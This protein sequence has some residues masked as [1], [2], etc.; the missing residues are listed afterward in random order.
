[1]SAPIAN[2]RALL[3]AT[4]RAALRATDAGALV[5]ARLLQ[6]GFKAPSLVAAFGKAS[7]PM[8]DAALS[9]YP[10][11][12]FLALAPDGLEVSPA[13]QAAL[14]QGQ[15][16]LHLARHPVP[17]ER[18]V[19]GATRLLELVNGLQAGADL[20][21]L[22][23][24]GGSAL[25]CAPWGVTLGQKQALTR[26]LLASGASIHD[27]NT[28]RKHLSHVKGGR[29]AQAALGRGASVTALLLSD[30]IGDDPSVIASGPTVPDASTFSDALAVLGR[31]G[32]GHPAA[33]AHL[34]RGRAGELP[35]T[36]NPG[37][38]FARVHTEVIGSN[39]LLLN[40]AAAHLDSQG[41]R[42]I[43]LG[44]A[45]GGEARDLAATH[46]AIIRSVY[47]SGTPALAPVALISGGEA[48]VTLGP[49]FVFDA[50]PGIGGRNQEF[51]LAFLME[52]G[53]LESEGLNLNL[54]GLSAGSDGIDGTS[55]AA[56]A[57]LMPDS[58]VR[59]RARGLDP[60]AALHRHDSGTF[61]AALGDALITGP[62]GQ[63]LNDLRVLL[64]L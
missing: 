7:L 58:L 19:R 36:P 16:E 50:A 3:D 37:P 12:R 21:V 31:F 30:V 39:R 22:G 57:F 13:V 54:W 27:L 47:T 15:G 17:D 6:P 24:G 44:D 2:P 59:A 9:V 14:D 38:A 51:A 52:M 41:V 20:L 23:S 64:A 49:A 10:N 18:G 42:A 40:A 62:T 34:Q 5:R 8:L 48:T 28:V 46:A 53:L 60:A 45:F 61:F 35:D 4:Y 63:N 29:L 11:S 32:L 55:A 43:I 25:L 33:R 26:D 56:G 1:M